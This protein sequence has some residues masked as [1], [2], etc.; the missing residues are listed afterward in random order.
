[1]G[2]IELFDEPMPVL[3]HAC[4]IF[5]SS[6]LIDVDGKINNNKI[7]NDY[8]YFEIDIVDVHSINEAIDVLRSINLPYRIT[9][10]EKKNIIEYI[11]NNQELYSS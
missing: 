4:C 11:K 9:L 3:I 7:L 1:M 6:V 5:N 2:D 8:D 10:E